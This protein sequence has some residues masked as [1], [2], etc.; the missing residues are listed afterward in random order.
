[1]TAKTDPLVERTEK[2]IRHD[3]AERDAF[4]V[5]QLV[6]LQKYAQEKKLGLKVLAAQTG[7]STAALSEMFN[8]KY[9]GDWTAVAS[10]IE[11]FWM[12][13]EKNRIFGG[14]R[15]FV[16]T[17]IAKSLWRVFEKTRYNRRIQIIQSHEQLGKSRAAQRY[18]ELN[19]GGRTV[20][21]T[22][23]PGGPSNGFG[24]FLR[25]LGKQTKIDCTN[26]KIID[27]RQGIIDR[28]QRCD[29]LIIDEWHLCEKWGDNAMRDLIDY[30]RVC[31]HNNGAR[32]IVLIAT[33]YDVFN[34]IDAFRKRTD[35]NMGQLLGRMCNEPLE[36]HPDQVPLD[37]VLGM[38]ERYFKPRAATLRKLYD[39]ATRPGLGHF[40]LL[41]DIL[42]RAWAIAQVDKKELTDELV[43]EIAEETLETIKIRGKELK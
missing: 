23:Q 35:Y 25:E 14:C 12:D 17:E 10:R 33:N 13:I 6:K 19:N 26:K 11:K 37:D 24:V 16:E 22:L 31:L 28:L 27:I 2:D 36:L 21:V 7:I 38:I 15:D 39:L 42:S 30:L 5:E 9:K 20:L 18:T 8:N 41:D 3:L 29:L 43:L 4:V 34:G 1:M 40:G 32:G